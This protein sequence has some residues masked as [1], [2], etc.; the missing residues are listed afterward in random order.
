M[1]RHEIIEELREK[2][3]QFQE[4]REAMRDELHRIGSISQHLKTIENSI[5]DKT[6]LLIG[7]LLAFEP[8]P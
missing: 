1:K 8:R 5:K 3:T 4:N 2:H 6:F 7:D